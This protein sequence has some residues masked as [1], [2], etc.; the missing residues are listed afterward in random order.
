MTFKERE[1]MQK[2]GK[3]FTLKEINV[4]FRKKQNLLRQLE[5]SSTYYT[6]HT[7]EVMLRN[8]A[9]GRILHSFN[10]LADPHPDKMLPLT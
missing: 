1:L 6:K 10:D 7:K 3:H 2:R 5:Q 8:L 4:K 9:S